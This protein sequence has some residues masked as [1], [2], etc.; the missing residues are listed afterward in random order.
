MGSPGTGT[1]SGPRGPP[2]ERPCPP[3]CTTPTALQWPARRRRQGEVGGALCPPG[4]GAL[5]GGEARPQ[6]AA[7]ER[8][9][10]DDGQ[11]G[12]GLPRSWAGLRS[13]PGGRRRGRWKELALAA[14]SPPAP[15]HGGRKWPRASGGAAGGHGV[16]SPACRGR[17]HQ[18]VSPHG[19]GFVICN[20]GTI[21][22]PPLKDGRG[23]Q[24]GLPLRIW[25]GPA[26]H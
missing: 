17:P 9:A 7:G 6:E 21:I 16:V 13:E 15:G 24:K 11:K 2:G 10:H 25:A 8:R 18:G 19:L 23:V 5:Q 3:P 1:N 14:Q 4:R 26:A 20:L 22:W 12:R